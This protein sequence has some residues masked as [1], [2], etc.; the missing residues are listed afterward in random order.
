VQHI[1]VGSNCERALK[2]FHG[3]AAVCLLDFVAGP[4]LF[5]I[6]VMVAQ[7]TKLARC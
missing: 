5:E 2:L 1:G 4:N 3:D 6:V 7:G